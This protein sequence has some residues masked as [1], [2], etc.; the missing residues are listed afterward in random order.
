MTVRFARPEELNFVIDA[1]VKSYSNSERAMLLTPKDAAHATRCA[2]CKTWLPKHDERGRMLAGHE[3]WQGQRRLVDRLIRRSQVLVYDSGDLLDGFACLGQTPSGSPLVHY[4]YVRWSSRG[5]GIA[6]ALLAGLADAQGVVYTHR[7][8]SL[9][10]A[11]LPQS[12]RYDDYA[13]YWLTEAA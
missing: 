9:E 12:W 13:L 3:Y 4:V 11:R 5:Q 7:T 1:W 6:K 2:Q 10:A 8:R